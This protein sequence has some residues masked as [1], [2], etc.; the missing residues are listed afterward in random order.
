MTLEIANEAKIKVIYFD[1]ES[2]LN[3]RKVF[4]GDAKALRKDVGEDWDGF[5][6]GD[7]FQFNDDKVRVFEISERF[8]TT[9]VCTSL[10]YFV[11]PFEL[12]INKIKYDNL[13]E[14]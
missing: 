9:G 1:D 13:V 7:S 3:Q 12:N 2:A 4:D 10:L 5:D 8:S 11:G 14:S 6:E